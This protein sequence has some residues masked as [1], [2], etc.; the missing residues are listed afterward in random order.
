[1]DRVSED[2]EEG[3]TQWEA[4]EAAAA[5]AEDDKD[6]NERNA[7]DEDGDG[8]KELV[9]ETTGGE[10]MEMFEEARPQ[11]IDRDGE[12]DFLLVAQGFCRAIDGGSMPFLTNKRRDFVPLLD[13]EQ[14]CQALGPL[15]PA[16]SFDLEASYD[17]STCFLHVLTKTL[18]KAYQGIWEIKS[19][20]QI[21]HKPLTTGTG[22]PVSAGCY[23]KDHHAS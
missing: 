16:I 10:Q 6:V 14:T 5:A 17:R 4:A 1:M 8:A 7:I 2:M 21:T 15:C 23:V 3:P 9:H 19:T 18:P 13:C 11:D 22:Y 20:D 12:V